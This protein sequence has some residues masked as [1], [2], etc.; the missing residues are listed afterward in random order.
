MGWG[1]RRRKKE[2][3][4]VNVISKEDVTERNMHGYVSKLKKE[5]TYCK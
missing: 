2:T 1:R 3:L 4:V 5:I